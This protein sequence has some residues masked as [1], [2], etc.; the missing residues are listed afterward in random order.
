MA[1]AT[2]ADI[3][4]VG[5][6]MTRKKRRRVSRKHRRT[7][8]SGRGSGSGRGLTIRAAKDREI[9][10]WRNTERAEQSESEEELQQKMAGRRIER[11]EAGHD[12]VAPLLTVTSC[13]REQDETNRSASVGCMEEGKMI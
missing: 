5:A 6:A 3:R 10:I 9:N 2:A 13:E 8:E 11:K 12:G 7:E 1:A 4:L